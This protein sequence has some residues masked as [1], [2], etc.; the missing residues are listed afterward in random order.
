MKDFLF[1]CIEKSFNTFPL[2]EIVPESERRESL[3]LLKKIV[4]S[5]RNDLPISNFDAVF[6]FFFL[7]NNFYEL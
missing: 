3:R 1:I 4:H 6:F 5:E 7:S 2:N